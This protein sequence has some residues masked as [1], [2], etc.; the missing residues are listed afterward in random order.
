MA[1]V[2]LVQA[3]FQFQDLQESSLEPPRKANS[4]SSS[5]HPS[6]ISLLAT[7]GFLVRTYY[8]LLMVHGVPRPLAI[9]N[10]T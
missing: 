6:L 4:N 8:Y 2:V 5:S 1:F 9:G 3:K 7:V 10:T